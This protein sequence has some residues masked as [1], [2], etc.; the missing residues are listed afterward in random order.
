MSQFD[1]QENSV[2]NHCTE[3]KKKIMGLKG[4]KRSFSPCNHKNVVKNTDTLPNKFQSI[5]S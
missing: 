4:F 1:S 3:I 5:Q 2:P